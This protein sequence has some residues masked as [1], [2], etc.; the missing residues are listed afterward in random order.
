MQDNLKNA[1]SAME[2]MI[3]AGAVFAFFAIFV[4][5][6]NINISDK[7][8]EGKNREF[9]K[10]TLDVIDEVSFATKASEGYERNFSIPEKV[11][12][13]FEYEITI[14]DGFVYTRATD[15]SYAIALPVQNVTGKLIKGGN[16]IKKRDGRVFLNE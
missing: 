3:L 7:L 11:S 6:L 9:E 16:L 10:I 5:V 4:F 8:K 14:Q 15:G 1:Q 13:R 2:F 12:G